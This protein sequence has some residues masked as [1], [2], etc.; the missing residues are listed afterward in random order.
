MS[1]ERNQLG[2]GTVVSGDDEAFPGRRALR[3]SP[4]GL[5]LRI[6][7]SWHALIPERAAAIALL[8]PLPRPG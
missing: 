8:E 3:R 5:E 1:T 2:D 7:G 6:H 4:G